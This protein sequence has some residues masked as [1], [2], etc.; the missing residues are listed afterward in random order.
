MYNNNNFSLSVRSVSK[1]HSKRAVAVP[2]QQGLC[3]RGTMICHR[4]NAYLVYWRSYTSYTIWLPWSKF[5]L[6]TLKSK[7]F[8]LIR[9]KLDICYRNCTILVRT[10][11]RQNIGLRNVKS[12]NVHI[13]NGVLMV[14]WCRS[15]MY[16]GVCVSQLLKKRQIFCY[17][18][19]VCDMALCRRAEDWIPNRHYN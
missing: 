14:K 16:R 5:S 2:S 10:L 7:F 19:G 3:E 8:M 4:Y 11:R 13:Y 18:S 15:K 1:M 6:A 9:Q 12:G 17:I